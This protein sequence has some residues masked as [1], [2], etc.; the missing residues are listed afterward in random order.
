MSK[1]YDKLVYVGKGKGA[2][3]DILPS[4]VS[5]KIT[6]DNP[7]VFKPY[8][9]LDANAVKYYK[10]LESSVGVKLHE[11]IDEVVES[12]SD[13][14]VVEVK[15]DSDKNLQ[16]VTSQVPEVE[17][18]VESDDK[19]EPIEEVKNEEPTSE[20]VSNK[21]EASNSEMIEFLDMNYSDDELRSIARDCG[22]K[23]IMSSW[24]K[25]TLIDKIISSNPEYVVNLMKKS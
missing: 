1:I 14:K 10:S 17:T 18:K 23:R 4:R 12:K 6:K 8:D 16:E 25:E 21:L 20:V 9:S 7:Y 2:I 3:V 24:D 13:N 22:I 19:K 15:S 5:I 11:I